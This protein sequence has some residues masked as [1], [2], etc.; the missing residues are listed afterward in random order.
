MLD[1]WSKIKRAILQ[2]YFVSYKRIKIVR[3]QRNI[4]ELSGILELHSYVYTVRISFFLFI[5]FR[6]SYTITLHDINKIW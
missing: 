6:F 2:R 1:H 3:F 5:Y 4:G